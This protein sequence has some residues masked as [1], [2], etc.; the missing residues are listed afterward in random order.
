MSTHLKTTQIILQIHQKKNFLTPTLPDEVEDIIKILNLR[1]S[2][3]PNSIINKLLK[4]CSKTIS[5]QTS[6][7]INQ[8]FV[9]G[10][11]Q[12]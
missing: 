3:G 9:T 1:K 7:L 10:I 4:K 8:S 11:L 5:I 6:K 2:I 12:V